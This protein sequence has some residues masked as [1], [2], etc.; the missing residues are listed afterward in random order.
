MESKASLKNVI[1]VGGGV[2]GMAA[3]K[4]LN[5]NH[6]H[7]HLV[8][9]R[10]RFGG[11]AADWACM[12]TDTCQSCSA[13]LGNEA[14]AQINDLPYV[15]AYL[16]SRITGVS[17]Q[18]DRFEAD[19]EGEETQKVQ[20]DDIIIAT[21]FIPAEPQGLMGDAWRRLPNVVTTAELNAM[22]REQV[23]DDRFKNSTGPPRI[24]FVQ[25]VGSRNREIGRDYCSQVCCKISM[26]Q[27]NKLLHLYPEAEITCFYIDLQ[28]IGKETRTFFKT[29]EERVRLIQGVPFEVFDDREKDAVSVISEDTANSGRKLS[30][31]DMLVLSGGLHDNK[32]VHPMAEDLG[33]KTDDFGFLSDEKIAE[34]GRVWIAGTAQG[35]M[36]IQGARQQGV[37]AARRIIQKYHKQTASGAK[38]AVIGD[39]PAAAG[40]SDRLVSSGFKVSRYIHAGG[41]PKKEGGEN[42]GDPVV[43]N[44]ILSVTGSAGQ[45]EVNHETAGKVQKDH[46]MAVAVADALDRH[47]PAFDFGVS[48]ERIITLSRFE[49]MAETQTDELPES[50]TFRL[51]HNGPENKSNAGNVLALATCLAQEAKKVT[52]IMNKMLVPGADGQRKYDRARQLGVRFLRVERPEDVRLQENSDRLVILLKEKTFGF[53]ELSFECDLLVLPEVIKPSNAFAQVA[54]ALKEPLDRE[55]LYQVN[56][57]RYLPVKGLKKGLF[58]LGECH[59]ETDEA[60]VSAQTDWIVTEILDLADGIKAPPESDIR[61][62]PIRCRKC[63]TCYRVCPHGAIVIDVKTPSVIP[64]NCVGCGLCIS[65]CPALAIESQTV[66]DA[67]LIESSIPQQFTVFACERSGLLA[68]EKAESRSDINLQ[69]VPCVCR[70]SENVLLKALEKCGRVVL[71]GCH[72]G[73]CRSHKGSKKALQRVERIKK[74]PGIHPDSIYWF[75]VAAN[76]SERFEQFIEKT[77]GGNHAVNYNK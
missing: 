29:L 51:D 32:S 55:G 54:A 35:P 40:L 60:Q 20:A 23:L 74:M 61:I 37:G 58:Y 76:E 33:L 6:I 27:I 36:D 17:K 1:I 68:A 70:I 64:S 69:A 10:D 66:A 31:F 9:S 4:T 12:A 30:H 50:I 49:R 56:N 16:N 46:V 28:I 22:F 5:D 57:V 8:E 59:D 15:A 24:G 39:G 53:A 75:P 18:A 2:A 44:R 38:V 45:F 73:N 26:R 43:L 7:A 77:I 47:S 41:K 14:A 3:A 63:L 11:H 67:N 62:N 21:G 25:C 65:S 19:I 13:C 52:V 72:D 48:E 42:A 34:G 71:S